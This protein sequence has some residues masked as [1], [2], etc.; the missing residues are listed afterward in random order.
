VGT[1]TTDSVR[2]RDTVGRPVYGV[3]PVHGAVYVAARD[4]FHA[5]GPAR[6]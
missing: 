1:H 4:A 3:T 5:F 2:I 6:A